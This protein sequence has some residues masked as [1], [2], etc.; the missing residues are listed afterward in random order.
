MSL[1]GIVAIIVFSILFTGIFVFGFRTKGP[2]GSGWTFFAV[3]ALTLSTV[4]LWVPPAGPVW[5]GAA[6]FDLLITGLLISFILSAVTPSQVEYR[7]MPYKSDVLPPDD[8]MGLDHTLNFQKQDHHRNSA[9]AAG[10]F[11]MLL[12]FLCV[13]I[14]IG[15]TKY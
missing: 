14:I 6:W 13:L 7:S 3:I 1:I 4:T 12:L 10:G 8:E 15:A 5:Y 2:W 9:I 11:W